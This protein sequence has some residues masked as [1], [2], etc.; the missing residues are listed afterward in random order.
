MNE[1]HRQRVQRNRLIALAVLG[2][3]VWLI[4]SGAFHKSAAEVHQEKVEEAK[5]ERVWKPIYEEERKDEIREGFQHAR[6]D[7]LIEAELEALSRP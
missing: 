7:A 3:I 1:Q 6:E 4:S 5:A 2:I